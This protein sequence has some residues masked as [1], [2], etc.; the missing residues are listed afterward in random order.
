MQASTAGTPAGLSTMSPQFSFMMA[1]MAA[2]WCARA[3]KH[4]QLLR[5]QVRDGCVTARQSIR[6]LCCRLLC[7]RLLCSRS[8]CAISSGPAAA[9]LQSHIHRVPSCCIPGLKSAAFRLLLAAGQALHIDCVRKGTHL[10]EHAVG[11][12]LSEA[13][14]RH[15]QGAALHER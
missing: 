5:M 3:C 1:L 4:S 15:A 13:L 12:L 8:G 11:G 14:L 7:C 9:S 10:L 2:A 6:L